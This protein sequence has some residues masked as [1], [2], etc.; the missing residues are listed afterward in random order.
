VS[1]P[2]NLPPDELTPEKVT[3]LLEAPSGERDLGADPET[4]LTVF[5]KSGR[6]GPYVQLGEPDDQEGKPKTSSLFSS[7]DLDSVTLDEALRLLALPRVVGED[8]ESGEEITAQSGRY[9]PYLKKGTDTR[10]LETEE[11][12]FDIDLAGAL[13]LFA[14]PKQRRGGRSAKPLKA[15]GIE[16][17]TGYEV[18]VRDGRFGPYVTDGGVN[19][20]LRR[21]DS[22]EKITI[23]RAA[24]LLAERRAKLESEGKTVKPGKKASSPQPGKTASSPQPPASSKNGE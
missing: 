10:S 24:E 1:V 23:E 15:L 9:G 22:V 21:E 3:E 4:G 6:F 18:D 7:M 17:G 12:I 8:P 20:S 13:A 2:E 11:Q 16:P 5:A 19:A 14:Q